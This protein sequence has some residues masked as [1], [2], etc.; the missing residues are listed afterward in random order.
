MPWIEWYCS[1]KGNQYYVQVDE[2]YVRDEFNLVGMYLLCS[3]DTF[4]AYSSK[5]LITTTR[6]R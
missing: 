4:Q 1:L 2:S 5:C 3:F 6:Y